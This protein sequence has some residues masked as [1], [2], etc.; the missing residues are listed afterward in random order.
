MMDDDDNERDVAKK[1]QEEI[2][3]GGAQVTDETFALMPGKDA[4]LFVIKNLPGQ[5]GKSFAMQLP[6]EMA[7][8]L[9]NALVACAVVVA[10]LEGMEEE[11]ESEEDEIVVEKKV[12]LH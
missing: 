7:V 3:D 11:T 1:I 5:E 2:Q 10:K 12:T 9:G 4:V 6:P 8:Q